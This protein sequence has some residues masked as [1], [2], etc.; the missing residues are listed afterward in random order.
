MSEPGIRLVVIVAIV[1]VVLMAAALAGRTRRALPQRTK[2]DDL[3]PGVHLFTSTTCATCTEARTVIASV[4]GDSFS[5]TRHEDDPQ[6]FGH[7]RITR[8]PTAIVVLADRNA[9]VFEGVPRKRHLPVVP[10]AS[11]ASR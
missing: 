3:P 4:Y 11:I 8:V 7:H 5:E 2:R 10:P 9:L 1:G 6:S